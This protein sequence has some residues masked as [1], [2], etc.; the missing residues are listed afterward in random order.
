MER[1]HDGRGIEGQGKAWREKCTCGYAAH[2]TVSSACFL[3][4]WPPQRRHF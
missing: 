2:T 1:I 4:E 3:V